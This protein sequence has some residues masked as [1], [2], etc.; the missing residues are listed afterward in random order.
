MVLAHTSGFP[1]WR[2]KNEPLKIHFQPGKRFSYS[3]EGLLYLQKVIEHISGLSLEDFI[4]FWMA[5]CIP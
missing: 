5:I 4:K 3:G 2:P 1:N